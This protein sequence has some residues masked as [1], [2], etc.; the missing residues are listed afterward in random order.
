DDFIKTLNAQL[1]EGTVNWAVVSRVIAEGISRTIGTPNFEDLYVEI[2]KV[3][4]VFQEVLKTSYHQTKNSSAVKKPRI[5]SKILDYLNFNFRAKKIAL[6][7]IDGMALWQ[8]E[9]LKNR[10][11]GTKHEEVIYS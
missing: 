9:L 7:V 10:L 2:N 3:N 4:I 5:V 6:I 1:N 8:Y 11:P